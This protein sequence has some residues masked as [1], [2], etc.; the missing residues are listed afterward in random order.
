MREVC[1]QDCILLH[2]YAALP[3]DQPEEERWGDGVVPGLTKRAPQS[4]IP[5][6]GCWRESLGN[7]KTTAQPVAPPKMNPWTPAFPAIPNIILHGFPFATN[8]D[9]E[10]KS[11]LGTEL[12]ARMQPDLSTSVV[13]FSTKNSSRIHSQLLLGFKQDCLPD[14]SSKTVQIQARNYSPGAPLSSALYMSS[15]YIIKFRPIGFSWP[16]VQGDKRKRQCPCVPIGCAC[17]SW[18]CVCAM[19][20]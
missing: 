15:I 5:F 14:S 20:W 8:S 17:G 10:N 12:Q 13:G 7:R 3:V 19:T 4:G 6:A 11:D 2:F 9:S 18:C 16:T 1:T